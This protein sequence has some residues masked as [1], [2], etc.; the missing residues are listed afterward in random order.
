MSNLSPNSGL[1]YV[2]A[3]AVWFVAFVVMRVSSSGLSHS[4]SRRLPSL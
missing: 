2:S 3:I 1:L 4:N